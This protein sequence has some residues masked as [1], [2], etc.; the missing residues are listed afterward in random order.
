MRPVLSFLTMLIIAGLAP[1]QQEKPEPQAEGVPFL[2]DLPV[3]GQLFARQDVKFEKLPRKLD[4][5]M[6]TALNHNPEL[7]LARARYEEAQAQVQD[8]MMK[9]TQAVIDLYHQREILESRLD[10]AAVNFDR[11]KRLADSGNVS[12]A[13]VRLAEQQIVEAKATLAQLDAHARYILG[14]GVTID[15][16]RAQQWL[17]RTSATRR[18]VH[19]S[20]DLLTRLEK[21]FTKFDLQVVDVASLAAMLK[22]WG[23]PAV[24]DAEALEDGQDH[25]VTLSF[26][27]LSLGAVLQAISD[28]QPHW[29][30]VGRDYGLLITSPARAR[31]LNAP[32]IPSDIPLDR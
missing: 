21:R 9:V 16:S 14:Q 2:R 12:H 8:A 25:H 24:V 32:T 22:D 20:P 26:D 18:P 27:D 10:Q 30:F 28:A 3:L 11:V 1:A 15:R 29:V 13:D 5:M 7:R 6:A 23:I 17:T 4:E 31:M 19:F